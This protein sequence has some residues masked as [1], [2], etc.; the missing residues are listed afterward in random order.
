MRKIL[1]ITSFFLITILYT[2]SYAD[3]SA[4]SE[5]FPVARDLCAGTFGGDCQWIGEG[6]YYPL[7]DHNTL[8]RTLRDRR[9]QTEA[10]RDEVMLLKAR[11]VVLGAK[12]DLELQRT[13]NAEIRAEIAKESCPSL[14]EHHVG[15]CVGVGAGVDTTGSI[16]AQASVI[17]GLRW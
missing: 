5:G 4:F 10:A 8:I 17:Y 3:S 6:V 11:L 12:L 14:W 2:T 16:D 1:S 7:Q 13:K 15:W 9:H